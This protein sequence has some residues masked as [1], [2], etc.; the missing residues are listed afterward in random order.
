MNDAKKRQRPD[1]MESYMSQLA[2]LVKTTSY[3]E[4]IERIQSIG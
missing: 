1:L 2:E 4:V 3:S